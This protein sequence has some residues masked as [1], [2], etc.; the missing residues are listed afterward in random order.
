MNAAACP[1][2]LPTLRSVTAGFVVDVV[3]FEYSLATRL[4]PFSV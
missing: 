2:L 1:P 4:A 3:A